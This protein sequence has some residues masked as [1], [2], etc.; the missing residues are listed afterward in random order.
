MN[1][2]RTRER[3]KKIAETK[4]PREIM[5][6]AESLGDELPRKRMDVIGAFRS[7]VAHCMESADT[8]EVYLCLKVLNTV[9]AAYQAAV[10]QAYDWRKPD[11]KALVIGSWPKTPSRG[12]YLLTDLEDNEQASFLRTD[13][14][15]LSFLG[16]CDLRR[17]ADPELE[18]LLKRFGEWREG[19]LVAAS[20][21][22][23]HLPLEIRIGRYTFPLVKVMGSEQGSYL[24][25]VRP[26]LI[27]NARPVVSPPVDTDSIP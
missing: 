27:Q 5:V 1:F 18:K 9:A 12:M 2:E 23:E 8:K 4:N 16:L 22:G 17:C 15:F 25:L 7:M 24:D 6:L 3:L 14:E 13:A 26:S 21:A 10:E 11:M 20:P 19:C